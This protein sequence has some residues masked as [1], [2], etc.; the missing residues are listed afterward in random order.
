MNGERNKLDLFEHAIID[1]YYYYTAFYN[2]HQ[3]IACFYLFGDSI[4]LCSVV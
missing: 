3:H 2:S 4:T 1:F